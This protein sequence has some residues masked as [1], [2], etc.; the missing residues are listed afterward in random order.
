MSRTLRRLQ[1]SKNRL[2]GEH[3]NRKQTDTLTNVMRLRQEKDALEALL[4]PPSIS[5]PVQFDADTTGGI[6]EHMLSEAD[7]SFLRSLKSSRTPLENLAGRVNKVITN[8]EPAIDTFADGIHKVN[9]YRIGADDIASQ[10][11]SICA[12]KLAERE[13]V[14][15]L[16]ALGGEDE[17][18]PGRDLSSV[19]RGLSKADR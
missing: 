12:S 10:V 14:G 8:L 11:L 6:D 1:N 7:A 2:G 15:R 16:K 19:L 4:R 17:R 5:E 9:R 3:R 18:S 13:R